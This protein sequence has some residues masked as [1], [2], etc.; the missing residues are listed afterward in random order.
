AV[1]PRTLDVLA[2]SK[3]R[4]GAVSEC[5]R[6]VA[7]EFRS[8]ADKARADVLLFA[9]PSELLAL[10]DSSPDHTAA[11]ESD[12]TGELPATEEEV[13]VFHDLLKATVMD[14]RVPVQVVR[15]STYDATKR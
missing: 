2:Q 13:P 12:E 15:P 5:V 9:L 14:L 6:M 3:D 4:R 11:A 10:V 1:T 7:D 8:L